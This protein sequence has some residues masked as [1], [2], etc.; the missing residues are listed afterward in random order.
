MPD[1]LIW[2]VWTVSLMLVWL[3]VFVW[4]REGRK[5]MLWASLLTTP[6]GLTEPLFVPEYWSP[7]SLFDLALRTGFDIESLIFCF[8]IGGLGVALYDVIFRI[9]HTHMTDAEKHHHRHRFHIWILLLPLIVFPVF[10]FATT[11]NPI[12]VGSLSMFVAGLAALYCRPDLKKKIW[13][14]GL[15][16]TIFYFIY[17]FFLEIA[18]P[19]YVERVWNLP[20]ISG[21]LV[22]SVPLEELMFAFTFGMLWSSYYEHLNWL[23]L[24]PINS[25]KIE[26]VT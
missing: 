14:S 18:S 7:P 20:A 16:F 19:G 22:F 1:N 11:W 4:H 23:K 24:K 5:P 17:F 9:E 6:F 15:M 2:F 8:G 3:V 26:G 13:G 21:V 10:F 12:Y 25:K